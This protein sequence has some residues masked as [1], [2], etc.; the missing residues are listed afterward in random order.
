MQ[1]GVV[2]PQTEIGTDA[3]SVR[4]FAQA[5]QDLGF[6]HLVT[7]DHVL[8]A[9]PAGHPGWTR[10]QIHTTVVHEPFVLLG[11][12][13]GVA[14]KLGLLTSVVILPQRQTALVAKQAAEV[15]V[16]S[17]GKLRLGVGIGWNPVEF[18]GLGMNFKDR[19]RRF[20]E[21]VDLMRKL[22]ND[23]SISYGGT[24][25][26]VTSAGISPLPI[27]RPIPIWVGATAESAV[28]RST[29]IAD[30]YLPLAPVAG[31]SSFDETMDKV[32][33]WLQEA[34]RDPSSF[35]VEARLNATTGTPDD[36]HKTVADWRRLGA[37]H[38]SVGTSGAGLSGVDAHIKRLREVQPVLSA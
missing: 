20:E 16:M 15:D 35:G 19:A 34:G 9:N 18:E 6:D 14:P 27:Q 21:Q 38:L 12:I 30:G 17:G 26:T 10:P 4:D 28:K 1:V 31:T 36:W 13:A 24:S 29:R 2:L 5:A 3:G 32:R 8:G 25:H 11:Y 37:T 7:S 33:G 22:W 23:E